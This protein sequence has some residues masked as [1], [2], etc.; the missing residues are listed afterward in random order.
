MKACSTCTRWKSAA[1]FYPDRRPG[2]SRDGLH[3]ACI[4]CEREAAAERARR[5]YVPTHTMRQ[6]RDR[7]GRFAR[8]A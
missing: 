1:E 3:H 6:A 7:A 5:R 2:R 8:A 4:A